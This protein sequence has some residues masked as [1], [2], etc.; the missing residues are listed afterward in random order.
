MTAARWG[1]EDMVSFLLSTGAYVDEIAENGDT[2]LILSVRHARL[3]VV[4]QLLE[5]GASTESMSVRAGSVRA[6]QRGA[7][8]TAGGCRAAFKRGRGSVFRG[9]GW[10]G[11]GSRGAGRGRRDNGGAAPGAGRRDGFGLLPVGCRAAPRG[12]E[13]DGLALRRAARGGAAAP[14]RG[15]AGP[16]RR[17]AL[18]RR[19]PRRPGR[20]GDDA[21]HARLQGRG[22]GGRA[23]PRGRESRDGFGS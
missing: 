15:P 11:A 6:S 22:R 19:R 21:A 16:S 8:R 4:R 1:R 5:F 2:A 23:A 13:G 7:N 12:E 10:H 18:P 14:R 9:A 17:G 3:G 20:A